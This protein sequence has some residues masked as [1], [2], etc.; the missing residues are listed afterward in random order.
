[1]AEIACAE[2]GKKF[3]KKKKNH[4]FCSNRCGTYWHRHA[5]PDANIRYQ[6]RWRKKNPERVTAYNKSRRKG[7]PTLECQKCG[8]LFYKASGAKRFCSDKCREKTYMS[9]PSVKGKKYKRTKQWRDKNRERYRIYFRSYLPGYTLKK[10]TAQPWFSLIRGSRL[11]AKYRGIKFDLDNEW[12]KKRWTGSCEL[13]GIP[14][15]TPENRRGY[16]LR[17]FF[18]SLDRIKPEKGYT[19]KNCRII[20]LGVN[21][22]KRDGTDVDMYRIAE[23]L[24]TK[25]G[26]HKG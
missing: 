1:M 19:K 16:K 2:C 11:R 15:A 8:K 3:R 24:I 14:F 7:R 17:N 22:L 26:A 9:K 6:R 10:L 18:P 5:N 20:L 23:A 4:R 13:T 25:R 12:A 21:S